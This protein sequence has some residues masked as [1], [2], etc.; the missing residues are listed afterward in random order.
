MQLDGKVAIITGGSRGIGKAIA[1][2]FVREGATAVICGR[3]A[4][5]VEAAA[6]DL[7][8]RT[9]PIAC[10]VGKLEGLQRLVTT[11]TGEHGRIAALGSNGGTNVAQ[12]PSLTIRDNSV[13]K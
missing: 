6:R 10:H 3:K 2:A 8:E 1:K 7:G 4:E 9:I 13:A 5:N 11:V 12:G